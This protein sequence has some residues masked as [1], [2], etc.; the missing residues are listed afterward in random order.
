MRPIGFSTGTLALDDW[1][2]ALS[3]INQSSSRTIELSALREKELDSLGDAVKAVEVQDFDHCCFHAPSSLS[4][5]SEHELAITLLSAIPSSWPIVV[6][7]E[8]LTDPGLWAA[9][10]SRLCIENMDVRKKTGRTA[11]ELSSIFEKFDYAS[12]CF[13]IG[14]ARHVD[15]TMNR[16]EA[17]MRTFLHRIKI[18]HLSEVDLMGNHIPLSIMALSSFS[19]LS[20]LIAMDCPIILESPVSTDIDTEIQKVEK[21]MGQVNNFL[22]TG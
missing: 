11:D 21:A 20:H 4:V 19:R 16:A 13:D 6:H 2:R 12:L 22:Q 14:H 7:P 15:R 8:I 1:Q 17:I 3:L 5:L 10:G 9:F 18:I